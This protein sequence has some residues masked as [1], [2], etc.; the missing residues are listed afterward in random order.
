ML[1]GF[2]ELEFVAGNPGRTLF[3]CHQQRHI[4]ASFFDC[5]RCLNT[6]EVHGLLGPAAEDWVS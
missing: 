3:H 5:W 1:G 6:S 2:Q 4:V